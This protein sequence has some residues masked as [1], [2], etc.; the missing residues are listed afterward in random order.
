MGF[1]KSTSNCP[2]A[3][4]ENSS[5]S[6]RR[7][8]SPRRRRCGS[9]SN[10]EG[11]NPVGLSLGL[12]PGGDRPGS[13]PLQE[14][15]DGGQFGGDEGGPLGGADGPGLLGGDRGD[16][17]GPLLGGDR[18][19]DDG[20]SLLGGEDGDVGPS[21]SNGIV[22]PDD[23]GGLS[24]DDVGPLSSKVPPEDHSGPRLR[25]PDEGGL[26]EPPGDGPP[27]VEV[28]VDPPEP[29]GA[30]LIPPVSSRNE[31]GD[32]GDP[33]PPLG[34]LGDIGPSSSNGI[35]GSDGDGWPVLVGDSAPPEAP[36]AVP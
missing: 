19:G 16:E 31:Y 24:G 4:Y 3:G 25:G 11:P 21:S 9:G 36:N 30:E 2:Y 8:S 1:W 15:S 20:P 29:N 10:G 13:D 26:E 22:G 28:G 14:L 5:S 7:S 35:V 27:D 34:E 12:D 32:S 33:A 18:G 6:F 23:V 17:D